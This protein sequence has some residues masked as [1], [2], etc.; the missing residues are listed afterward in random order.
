MTCDCDVNFHKVTAL[1]AGET[2]VNMTVTNSTNISSLDDFQL[3]LCVNPASVVTGAP[4]PYTVTV[5][6]TA[7]NLYNKYA[8]PIYTNRLKTRKVYNGAFVTNGNTSYVILWDTP[9]CAR[10]A[11][12]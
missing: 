4:L 8:L 3:V 9:G 12:P 7:Y 2:S 11:K 6:G 10:Y 1:T 5:N